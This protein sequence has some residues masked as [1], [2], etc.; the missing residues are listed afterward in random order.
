MPEIGAPTG[1][2]FEITDTKLYVP[3]VTLSTEDDNKL[4]EQLK[5]GFTRTIKWQKYTSEMPNPTE[6]HNL[7][8][9]IDPT[10]SKV[11]IFFVLSFKNDQDRT[12]F[13]KFY[14]LKVEMKDFN[15]LID[16]KG[17]FDVPIKNKEE[18]YE[19]IIEISKNND[20]KTGNLLDYD[21]FSNHYKLIVIDLSKQIELENPDLKQQINFIRRIKR[22]EGATM[23]F[24]IEKSK[25]TTFKFSQ[26]ASTVV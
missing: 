26:N 22:H 17:F 19:K 15:V 6:I 8:Y 23:F 12:S 7:N 3:A 10:F 11:N 4:L 14:T 2:T 18:T 20:H 24:I 25:E 1:T 13:T 5:T 16:G 21:Y 9:L